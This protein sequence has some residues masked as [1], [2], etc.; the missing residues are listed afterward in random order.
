M[1]WFNHVKAPEQLWNGAALIVID[2]EHIESHQSCI[3]EFGYTNLDT[4]N[5]RDIAI[6]EWMG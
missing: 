1:E 4:R 6:Q 3:R 5:I 2:F